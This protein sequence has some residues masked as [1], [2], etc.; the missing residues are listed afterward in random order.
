MNG[1]VVYI[2]GMCH[3]IVIIIILWY[4]LSD[5][6]PGELIQAQVKGEPDKGT[7][8]KE[9]NKEQRGDGD[10]VNPE[11]G[12]GGKK[13]KEDDAAMDVKVEGSKEKDDDA[14]M[15]VKGEGNKEKDDN[16]AVDVKVEDPPDIETQRK[17]MQA[18]LKQQLKS[19][20]VW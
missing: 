19:G 18:A 9:G 4:F 11:G 6:L 13:E 15:E 20:Q 16:D 17:E 3:I 10:E 1:E 2:V 5:I 14:E 12:E 7:E 8:V